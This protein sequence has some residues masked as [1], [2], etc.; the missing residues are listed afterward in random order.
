MSKAAV[1]LCAL[2]L[3][4]RA[5]GAQDLKFSGYY[6]NLV[7][8]SETVAPA[9]QRYTL[10]L[11]RVRL[12]LKGKLSENAALDPQYDNEMLLGN[13]LY[14]AQFAAQKDQRPMGPC[15][16]STCLRP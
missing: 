1:V 14:T 4:P 16:S 8:N 12:E 7:V 5:A 13:Y 9:G 15:R 10:D 11:N 2:A 6:K 3:L